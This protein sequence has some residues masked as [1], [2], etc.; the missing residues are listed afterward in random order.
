MVEI[1]SKSQQCDH[2][3]FISFMQMQVKNGEKK[4][5]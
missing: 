3:I 4:P 1:L 5:Q 2:Y